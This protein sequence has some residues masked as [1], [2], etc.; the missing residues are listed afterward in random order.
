VPPDEGSGAGDDRIASTIGIDLGQSVSDAVV[1]G[2]GG[3]LLR[4]HALA[5]R[6]REPGTTLEAAL[7]AIADTASLA[8]VVGLSGGR[9]AALALEE[10]RDGRP[11]IVTVA[12]PE[13]I[14]RGGLHLS[15]L[16]AALV[17]SCGT[18]T[19]MVIG[20]AGTP[21]RPEA[22]EH[23][24]G[25]PVGGGTLRALGRLLLGD[26]DAE[27]LAALAARGDASR[28]DTTLADVLG[29]GLGSLPPEATAVSLGRLADAA[30][31]ADPQHDVDRADL[32]AALVTMVAQ[33]IAIIAVNAVRAHALPAV[34]MVGRVATLAPVRSM[35]HSV[36]R[37][38]GASD[39][40][41]LPAGAGAAT[42]IGAA[43]AAR[44][45]H[46]SG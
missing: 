44:V 31:G 45:R 4:H 27:A 35:L 5:V 42:A 32:A 2:P 3:E 25:T 46:P 30:Q 23:A 33:T 43:L 38:Y 26:D 36:F 18:G 34:V 12:E 15:G 1:L 9:S 17:V 11:R 28:V 37:V 21:E 41:H 40:L 24:T 29:T 19:A 39:L 14:G 6:G 8:R 20:R 13:A 7:A 16:P 10:R 22:F